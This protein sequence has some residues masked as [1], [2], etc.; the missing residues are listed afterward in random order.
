[1][2]T[3]PQLSEELGIPQTTLRSARSR[4]VF[5][6]QAA[7]RDWLIDETSP[8]FAAWLEARPKQPRLIGAAKN[9]KEQ[10]A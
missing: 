5:P 1:M 7:G 6:S 2:K 9:L 4:N 8:E 10:Q 3:I